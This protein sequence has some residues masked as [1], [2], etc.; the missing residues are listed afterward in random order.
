M[1]TATNIRFVYFDLGNVLV[2]F[3][4][5]L[6]CANVARCLGVTIE[7]AENAIYRSGL[8]TRFEHGEISADQYV[9]FLRQQIDS[10]DASPPTSDVLD[11]VSEMFWPIESMPPL[12]QQVRAKRLP[13][14]VLSNTC[15]AHWDW[16]IRQSY[17]VLEGEFAVTI[18]S[19]EVGSM[20]PD[21][22][23][24]RAAELAANVPAGQILLLDD[25]RENVQAARSRG[26]QAEQCTGGASVGTA[27]RKHGVIA[28]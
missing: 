4:P 1:Q 24:Y 7:Q 16:I 26:W 19:Y 28:D 6:A 3:D 5:Q 17:P 23:I 2:A 15:S 21:A 8:Q 22:A 13:V 27:L 11:A 25:K 9:A 12:L 18:L 10:A 14:G 20:K